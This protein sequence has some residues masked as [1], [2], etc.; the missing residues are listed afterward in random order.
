M[1]ILGIDE[2]GRGCVLGPMVVG[3]VL[4]EESEQ[5]T[6]TELGVRDSKR[7]S[8][9]RREAI[10]EALT[11]ASCTCSSVHVPPKVIDVKSLNVIMIDQSAGFIDDHAPDVA[12]VDAPTR[13]NGLVWYADRILAKTLST[14]HVKIISEN[15]ADTN[16]VSVA[17]ASIVAKVLRDKEIRKMHKKYNVDFGS[18]YQHDPKTKEFLHD[19]Y[20]THKKLPIET[21]LKWSTA[22]NILANS[23]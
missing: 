5:P 17:A 23:T 1:K 16:H 7:L 20:N 11:K 19:Y 15:K 13:G 9:K 4:V 22:Q 21:R 12:I 14:K 8:P 18:G 2:A 3:A 6:L 10:Y